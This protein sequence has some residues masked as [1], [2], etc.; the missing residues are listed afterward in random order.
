M[1]NLYPSQWMLDLTL[2]QDFSFRLLQNVL[3][4]V[5]GP[6][7]NPKRH[8]SVSRTAFSGAEQ[9]LYRL[10][11]GVQEVVGSG[12][13]TVVVRP[14]DVEGQPPTQLVAYYEAEFKSSGGRAFFDIWVTVPGRTAITTPSTLLEAEAREAGKKCVYPV[15]TVRL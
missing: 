8:I 12:E 10:R 9:G 6:Y 2:Q 13:F 5:Q 7:T 3:P 1:L 14:L 15:L 11:C 4:P